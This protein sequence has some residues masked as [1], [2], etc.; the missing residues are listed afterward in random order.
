MG[1]SNPNTNRKVIHLGRRFD[2]KIGR[3]GVKG[4]K[5]DGLT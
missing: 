3:I 5:F 1:K 2:G 4:E